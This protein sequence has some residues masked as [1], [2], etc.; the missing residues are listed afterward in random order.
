MSERI[1][2]YSEFWSYYLREHAKAATRSMHY[3]GTG[4]STVLMIVALAMGRLWLAPLALLAGYGPAWIAHFCVEKNHPATFKYPLWSLVSDYRMAFV[5]VTG[6]LGAE[7]A[8]AG[9]ETR[10]DV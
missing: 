6:R 2:R 5:W 1:K 4:L 9:F 8:K 7:L 10:R 3:V